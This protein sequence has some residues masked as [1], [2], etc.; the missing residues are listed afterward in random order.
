MPWNALEFMSQLN[1]CGDRYEQENAWYPKEQW[2]ERQTYAL[3]AWRLYQNAA[4]NALG[5]LLLG[6]A[7]I[8]KDSPLM[9]SFG[10]TT[11]GGA[12]DPEEQR[13]VK[14]LEKQ[15]KDLRRDAPGLRDAPAVQGPG[16]IL[17]EIKWTPLLNDSFILGG[18]H[19]GHEFHL[20]LED[21]GWYER[22]VLK[23]AAPTTKTLAQI[24]QSLPESDA[25]GKWR[26]FFNGQPGIFWDQ[27]KNAP[28]VLVREL[29]GL[30]TCGY[31]ALFHPLQLSFVA[32]RMD[33][34]TTFTTYLNSLGAA[35]YTNKNR[36]LIFNA[37]SQFL[38]QKPGMLRE[39]T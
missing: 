7:K 5:M 29:I 12:W 37:L 28:R 6:D 18:A 26:A 32:T 19:G 27:K 31:R 34:L 11:V 21:V 25:T 13:L 10:I 3:N 35:G 20:A 1:A 14:E 17:S 24:F 36:T 39:E 33:S 38:F 30:K 9:A 4:T 23:L 22:D 16:S 15:R 2:G 8:R